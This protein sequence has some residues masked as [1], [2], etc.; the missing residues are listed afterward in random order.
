M[1]EKLRTILLVEDDD[2]DI[3]NIQRAFQKNQMNNPIHIARDGVEALEMLSGARGEK[4]IPQIILLDINMPKM[5]GLEFLKNLRAD[6]KLK[7]ISVFILTTSAQES[8]KMEAHNLNVAGYILKQ[9]SFES[10]LET[11]S[12]LNKFWSL[13]EL[14]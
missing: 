7:A 10:F 1:T 5:G 11:I 14:P 9:L 4:V 6:D 8:D 2:V 13:C 12:V 3:M